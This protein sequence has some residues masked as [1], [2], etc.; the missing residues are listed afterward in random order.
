MEK[1]NSFFK[2]I[3]Q[4]TPT[5]DQNQKTFNSMKE[6][7]HHHFKNIKSENLL[8][9]ISPKNKLN[10]SKKEYSSILK[11]KKKKLDIISKM[12]NKMNYNFK[13]QEKLNNI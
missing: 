4:L 8:S 10:S 2:F 9:Y 11:Q 1:S 12:E 13:S 3:N 6:F 5:K 7:F